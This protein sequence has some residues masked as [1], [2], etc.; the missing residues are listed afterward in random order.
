MELRKKIDKVGLDVDKWAAVLKKE[1]GIT[2]KQALANVTK[3][4]L[5][6]VKKYCNFPWETEALETL[7]G[8]VPLNKKIIAFWKR[9][10][11]TKTPHSKSNDDGK[12]PETDSF[13]SIES[14]TKV[15]IHVDDD[16]GKLPKVVGV[17]VGGDIIAQKLFPNEDEINQFSGIPL[18]IRDQYNYNTFCRSW[19]CHKLELLLRHITFSTW[20]SSHA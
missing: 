5:K 18:P 14:E 20:T 3:K 8:V 15:E 4:D 19:W 13:E 2:S 7:F 16:D 9:L 6:V 12:D 17:G 10:T 1:L 11:T